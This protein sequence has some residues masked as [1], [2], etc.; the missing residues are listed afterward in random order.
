MKTIRRAVN[1]T[2][3][4]P[5]LAHSASTIQDLDAANGP[6]SYAGSTVDNVFVAGTRPDTHEIPPQNLG[7]FSLV[8][9]PG[10]TLA[11]N[12]PALAAF[13]RAALAWAARIADPITVTINADLAP[14]GAGILG[15]TSATILQA[16][17]NTLRNQ[18]VTDAADEPNNIIMASTPTAAQFSVL[19][20]AG[21]TLT[22]N[23]LGT[24]AN[25]KAMGFAGLDGTFGVSD[26]NITFSTGFAFDYDHSNGVTP[27][28]YDFETVAA[29]EIGHVLGFISFLDSIDTGATSVSPFALDLLRFR[30][31][32]AGQDPATSGDFTTFPRH[33]VPN[34]DAIT[35][36]I[37]DPEW[38]MSTGVNGGDGRQGSHWKSDELTG[39]F[40]GLMD[41]TLDAGVFYGPGDPDFRSLDLIGYEVAPI[42]EPG[43]VSLLL[44]SG[45]LFQ[46]FR[47]RR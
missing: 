34:P 36:G 26:G 31:N 33:L 5:F 7:P 35:D 6:V 32:V 9:V 16:G 41:P 19:M 13:N 1:L 8:I 10:P 43:S 37:N 22:G 23:L 47:R 28:T 12:A 11:A 21:R 2:V 46:I 3:L 24:K 17:Y 29:H 38:R 15:S 40:I 14:L 45:V 44:L 27:G 18:M 25:L 4:L 39:V 20:P 30:N 42:P